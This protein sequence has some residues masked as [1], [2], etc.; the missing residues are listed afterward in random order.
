MIFKSNEM[1]I[2]EDNSK[3]RENDERL[4]GFISLEFIGFI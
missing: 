1:F 3:K 2:V 4:P